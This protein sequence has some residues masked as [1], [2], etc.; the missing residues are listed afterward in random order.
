ML[1]S[2]VLFGLVRFGVEVSLDAD[3]I[4][5]LRSPANRDYFCRSLFYPCDHLGR[6]TTDK[7]EENTKAKSDL[8]D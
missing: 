3:T 7:M 2:F 8:V 6:I 4:I 1:F 5:T